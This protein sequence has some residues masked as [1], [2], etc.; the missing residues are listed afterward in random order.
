MAIKK[1]TTKPTEVENAVHFFFLSPN[2]ITL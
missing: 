2:L 1:E